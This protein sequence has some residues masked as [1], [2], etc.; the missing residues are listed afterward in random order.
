MK[1]KSAATEV[2]RTKNANSDSR[3]TNRKSK[4]YFYLYGI[5]I[6]FFRHSY[7]NLLKMQIPTENV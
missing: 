2:N 4:G 7:L 3:Q 1:Q 6:S 5:V